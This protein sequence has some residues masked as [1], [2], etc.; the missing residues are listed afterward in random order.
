MTRLTNDLRTGLFHKIMKGL[1]NINYA[2]KIHEVVQ[3][4]VIKH[5]PAEVQDMYADKGL[6]PYLN[7]HRLE[8]KQGNSYV[9]MSVRT[10]GCDYVYYNDLYGLTKPMT[11]QMD[12]NMENLLKAGSLYH[13]VYYALK[14][15]GYVDAYFTQEDL[16]RDV[17]R[18][19]KANL[20]AA[21][22]IK[23][24][25]DVLEPE[26]HH[27]IPKDEVKETLPACVAPVV[28]DLR[29]LGAELPE[30][31]KAAS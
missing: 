10:T 21:T 11:V 3:S 5:A 23:R 14:E 12:E 17:E 19:L 31:Q 13:D 6:R 25:Y 15:K 30:V 27:F 9:S 26:L 29:K 24:L 20:T 22:T 16:R 7:R 8:V 4:V 28:D 1:P 2:A 18:R